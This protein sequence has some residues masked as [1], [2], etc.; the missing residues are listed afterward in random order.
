MS[1]KQ[2][3]KSAERVDRLMERASQALV[4]TRY[5][6]AERL[7]VECL[8]VAHAAH[9]FE[10]MARVL[11]PLQEARRQKRQIAT[12]A[13]RRFLVSSDPGP[14][15]S[16]GCYLFQPPLIGADARAFRDAADAAKV[17]A[18]VLT[19]EPLT[20]DGKW[21]VVAVGVVSVRT[22]VDPPWPLQRVETSK[23]KDNVDGVT[24]GPPPV[25]WFEAAAEAM[26]D[27]AIAKVNPEDPPAWQVEDLMEFLDAHPDHELL[28]QRLADTCR[29]AMS[30]PIPE[31]KRRRTHLDHPYSF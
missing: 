9:D 2:A 14:P 21:P 27:A 29:A 26:G 4:A 30:Q 11:L 31:R 24:L 8:R 23:T 10:R 20:R 3:S 17:P 1:A 6:E 19:R 13:D 22:K 18:L 12:E 16:P 15:V 28:H 25:A 5:F 7:C